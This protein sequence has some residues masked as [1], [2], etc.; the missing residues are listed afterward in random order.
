MYLVFPQKNITSIKFVIKTLLKKMYF[1]CDVFVN[2]IFLLVG[3]FQ[4]FL[5]CLK[6]LSFP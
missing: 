5:M 2:T 6:T 1:S 3:Q 4:L